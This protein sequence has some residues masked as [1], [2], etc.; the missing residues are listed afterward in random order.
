MKAQKFRCYIS[1]AIIIAL[2]IYH[3]LIA[4]AFILP[5]FLW[6]DI[7]TRVGIFL[8]VIDVIYLLPLIF[9]TYYVI[10][11][12]YLFIRQWP[13]TKKKIRYTDIFIIDN[14][15]PEG[16]KAKSS[17]HMGGKSIIIGYYT[18]DAEEN[19]KKKSN[20]FKKKKSKDK[21][22]EK[23]KE[24]EINPEKRTKNYV[25]INPSDTDL[26]L[27]KLG[28]KFSTAKALAKKLEEERKEKNAEHYRKKSLADRK[29]KEKEEAAKPV[30]V[31]IDAK[32][33]TDTDIEVDTE[34]Q[35]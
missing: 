16:A 13:F 17:Y 18:Y 15:M 30:D 25:A 26:F 12:K 27:I 33:K 14:D 34:T 24:E 3:A 29:R 2:F 19:E 23:K 5:H 1:P 8:I 35:E 11:D 28:G 21:E 9:N 6:K 20:K 4:V 31:V 32:L 10:D 7:T 22:K